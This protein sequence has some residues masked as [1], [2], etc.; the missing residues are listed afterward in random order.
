MLDAD[1][2][3]D[4]AP[5]GELAVGDRFVVRPGEKVATD[6]VVEHG[7][8]AID[9][10]MVTGESVP[11]EV[12]PGATVVGATINAGG[13]LVVGPRRGED[14]QLA[15]MVRLVEQAQTGK[16]PVQHLA[17]RI[18]AVF[19]PAV[20]ALAAATLGFWL[21]NTGEPTYAFTA[22]VSVLI[23]ACPCALG[24]AT[25][26]A[27]MVGTGRGAP[28]GDPHQGS[29]GARVHPPG[30]HRRAGQ[31]RNG[32]HRCDGPR[33]RRATVT[34]STD[35]DALRLVG[36]LEAASEHPIGRAMA[37]A[38][39]GEVGRLPAV[40]GFATGP[41]SAWRAWSTVTPS[42][43]AARVAPGDWG[44]PAPG[45]AGAAARRRG[46]LRS[47]RHRRRVGTAGHGA[48][49]RGRHGEGRERRGR[50]A[51]ASSSACDPSCSRVTTRPPPQGGRPGRHPT[52]DVVAE[53][54][55][56]DKVDVV[57]RL[58]DEGRVVAM[59]GDGVNDAAALAQADLGIA[60]GTG[61]DVAIEAS[62]LTLVR[63]T[64]GVRP[65]PSGWL[66][67]PSPPSRAT[68]SGPSPTT[69]PPCR[70]PP[71]ATSTPSW[72][73]PPWPSHPCSSSR[74]ACACAG[75]SRSPDGHRS[76]PAV[77][78]G[79]LEGLT[80]ER[81]GQA[82]DGPVAEVPP[83]TFGYRRSRSRG[84]REPDADPL[85]E[86][87]DAGDFRVLKDGRRRPGSQPRRPQDDERRQ[88]LLH[89]GFDGTAGR[90][91]PPR[92]HLIRIRRLVPRLV[93]AVPEL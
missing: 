85:L 54:L 68:C 9:E 33:G 59:V 42:W 56:A 51:P 13:R 23:I 12:G 83:F 65:T 19:V 38:A 6:G 47:H 57:K 84:L 3:N 52:D 77:A 31:D 64:Y 86:R 10:S 17:D 61:T 74:T 11:V 87:V 93:D 78:D 62:D 49:R 36:A 79:T 8:S 1:G 27:L 15:Q 82:L 73:A 21:A 55:P 81:E 92:R 89:R 40:E 63:V 25:P 28:V 32:H 46:G 16:A 44:R 22:A 39:A 34:A 91:R 35:D 43:R 5:I 69:S 90:S 75:S 53:V 37:A 20:M 41:A 30:R 71:P 58:Q 14:T 7:T 24:L 29:R 72:P 76:D 26:T 4:A 48:V 88:P 70:S 50:V 60:M 66:A 2:R 67:A 18:S 80:I 45:G